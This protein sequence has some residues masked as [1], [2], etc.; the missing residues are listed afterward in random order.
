MTKPR[1]A[2]AEKHDQAWLD[3]APFTLEGGVALT[4]RQLLDRWTFCLGKALLA[5]P[6][7]PLWV[8]TNIP[9]P[10][11]EKPTPGVFFRPVQTRRAEGW[12]RLAVAS[13]WCNCGG[14]HAVYA[15]MLGSRREFWLQQ[16]VALT[17]LPFVGAISRDSRCPLMR[18]CEM[19]WAVTLWAWN[20]LHHC[21]D[22]AI[23]EIP[24][25]VA[26]TGDQA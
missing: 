22:T 12:H 11:Q 16:T 9:C 26:Q 19:D 2:T 14:S 5:Y 23:P 17:E 15:V 10:L 1:P 21:M 18:H 6:T 7:A 3:A 8:S 4:F 13:G 25:R 24:D 20:H